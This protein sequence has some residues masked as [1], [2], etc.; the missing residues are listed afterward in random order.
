MS[1]KNNMVIHFMDGTKVVYD[2]P[3]QTEDSNAVTSRLKN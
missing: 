1:E 2:F 3:K